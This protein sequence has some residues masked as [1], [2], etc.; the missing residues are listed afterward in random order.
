MIRPI[1]TYRAVVSRV[2]DGDTV[3]VVIDLGFHITSTLRVRVL[4]IDAPELFSGDG[5][6]AGLK[7]KND[8]IAWCDNVDYEVIITTSKADGFGRWLA[9]ITDTDNNSLTEHLLS[10]GYEPYTR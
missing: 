5:R 4:G 7:A 6:D 2:I 3:E 10:L 9:E 1:Y 8:T